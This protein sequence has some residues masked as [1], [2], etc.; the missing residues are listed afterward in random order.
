MDAK[1]FRVLPVE[2][3]ALVAMAVLL[4]GREAAVYLKNDAVN[5]AGLHRAALDLAGQPPDLRMPFVGTMLRMALQEM[6]QAADS[7][8]DP[9]MRGRGEVES[10][11]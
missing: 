3:R 5:G 8:Q 4:D 2:Q 10:A 7:V 9:V 1:K 11:G 6:E